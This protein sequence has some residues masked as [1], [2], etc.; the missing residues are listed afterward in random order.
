MQVGFMTEQRAIHELA[1]PALD[2]HVY[3]VQGV[4]AACCALAGIS[5]KTVVA[6]AAYMPVNTAIGLLLLGVALW[7]NRRWR[8]LAAAA[9]GLAAMMGILTV[10]EY[11]CGLNLHVDQLIAPDRI[12]PASGW[13][14]GRM[15]LPTAVCFSLLGTGLALSALRRAISAIQWLALPAAAV[16]MA[17]LIG[18]LYGLDA[19]GTRSFMRM[20]MP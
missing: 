6:G 2:R 15:A 14:P 17:S 7:G 13:P 8:R 11:A 16:S 10:M 4:A 20:A 9:G 3:L 12:Q 5:L 18:S 19:Y 1:S